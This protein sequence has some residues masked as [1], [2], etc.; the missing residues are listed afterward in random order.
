VEGTTNVKDLKKW[1]NEHG[2]F[3]HPVENQMMNEGFNNLNNEKLQ[4]ANLLNH[5]HNV[6]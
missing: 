2:I 5:A 6:P 3:K 4:C 1:C